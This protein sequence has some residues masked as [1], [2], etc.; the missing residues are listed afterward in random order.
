MA[1]LT[2]SSQKRPCLLISLGRQCGAVRRVFTAQHAEDYDDAAHMSMSDFEHVKICV[3]PPPPENGDMECFKHKT[4]QNRYVCKA[5]CEPGFEFTSGKPVEKLTCSLKSGKWSKTVFQNV[6]KSHCVI[7]TRVCTYQETGYATIP[8]QIPGAFLNCP[9]GSRYESQPAELYV[10]SLDGTWSPSFAPKCI[11][12][13]VIE[14]PASSSFYAISSGE[15][16]QS[17]R[18]SSSVCSTWSASHYRTFD[19]GVYSFTSPCSYLFAKDCEQ[20]TFAIHIHNGEYC[21]TESHCSTAITIYIGAEMYVLTSGAEGPY[22]LNGEEMHPVPTSVKGLLFQM[23]SNYVTVTSPL[24]FKLKWNLQNTILLEVSSPLKNR[25]CGLCG[26]FDGSVQNDFG[27]SDGSITDSVEGF[28]N[29]WAMEHIGGKAI[30]KDSCAENKNRAQEAEQNCQIIYSDKFSS[31]HHLVNPKP[32]FETCRMD[33]CGCEMWGSCH[34]SSLTEYFRECVRLGGEIPGGWRSDELCPLSC[35]G[36]MVY[37]DCG[38]SCPITCKGTVYACEDD[39][40]IDGCHCPEGTALHDGRCV[41]I[42]S[43]PCLHNEKEYQ[44]GERIIQDCNACECTAGKWQC[45][46][47]TCQARCS[48]TGDPHYTTFDGYSYEFLGSCPYYLVYN[49][50][51]KV[52]QE[53]GPCTS[54]LNVEPATDTMFCTHSVTVEY[55]GNSLVLEPGIKVNYFTIL[56]GPTE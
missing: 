34:C 40:C 32:Y 45:T 55:K 36:G 54:E 27:T 6:Y 13:N 37:T 7:Q 53:N 8:S 28:V 30:V 44:S 46:E 20:N 26:K 14:P 2:F 51:F 31:C 43:C 56:K 18:P 12:I 10:C 11:P 35:P 1:N 38:T 33:Y 52:I 4:K 19:G 21:A 17:T 22:I 3:D 39:R 23:L 29:S 24:G 48:S 49:E 16:V 25:T 47:E 42:F 41:D 5:K 50:D 15:V 9:Q